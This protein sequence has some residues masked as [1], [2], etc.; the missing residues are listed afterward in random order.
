V[1]KSPKSEQGTGSIIADTLKK[2]EQ[3]T[4]W[5][6][7]DTLEGSAAITG[8]T[9]LTNLRTQISILLILVSLFCVSACRRSDEQI[10]R[11][12]FD[13]PVATELLEITSSPPNPG[14]FGREGLRI[15]AVFQFAQAEF[16]D[17]VKA[18]EEEGTWAPLPPSREFITRITGVKSHLEALCR[19]EEI[20]AE[21]LPGRSARVLPTEEELLENWMEQLPFDTESGMY[22]CK[23]AGDNLLNAVKVPCRDRAGD[24]NDFMLAVLDEEALTLRVFVHTRY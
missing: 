12:E 15:T 14:W 2:F 4:G 23:T 21:E 1:Q 6:F 17:Y 5:I 13:I 22:E 8:A 10:L 18:A 11:D 3:G 16:Q 20:L 7:T 24:L 19:S 9:L